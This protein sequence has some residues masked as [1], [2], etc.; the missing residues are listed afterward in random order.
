LQLVK[1]NEPSDGARAPK[2]EKN[3]PGSPIHPVPKEPHTQLQI[4]FSYPAKQK[5]DVLSSEEKL[6]A[7]LTALP[8]TLFAVDQNGL[9]TMFEGKDADPRLESHGE[10]VGRNFF[11]MY[12]EL[13]EMKR[14]LVNALEGKGGRS[15]DRLGSQLIEGFFSPIRDGGGKVVGALG[16]RIDATARESAVGL[17]DPEEQAEDTR[18]RYLALASHELRTPLNS[19]VG[20]VNLLLKNKE[21][22]FDEEDLF[23]L[24]RILG[25]ATHLLNVVT[26]MLDISAIGTGKLSLMISK[27]EVDKLIN[28]TMDELRGHDGAD[29]LRMIAEIPE[30]VLPIDADRQK[31]K[32]VLI[33][34]LGNALKYTERGS[35]T[36]RL[37][38][39]AR[40]RPVRINVIDTGEG[41]PKD[42]LD[43]I[44]E[45]FVRVDQTSGQDVEGT[46]LG[47][48]FSRSLCELMGYTIG[49]ESA[50]GKGSTFTIHLT[51][52]PPSREL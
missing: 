50:L 31:L 49:V 47:L 23:Y 26:H 11:E 42:K 34:L 28:E 25:N 19:V 13:P 44:F 36:V 29:S 30:A 38:V 9:L 12:R 24:N 52:G 51:P 32:Q 35:I 6:R 37:D 15:M 1:R 7:I 17:N 14:Q 39:D 46:G 48:T 5:Q 2:S 27:T 16:V 4:P 18:T 3:S 41:I 8:L 33:N 45:A 40:R 21:A 43:S 10:M 20:F 22:R